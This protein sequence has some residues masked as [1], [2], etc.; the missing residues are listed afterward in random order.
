M[1]PI[2]VYILAVFME[3]LIKNKKLSIAF[4]SIISSYWQLFGYGIGF[5]DELLTGRA[6]KSAQEKLYK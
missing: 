1:L 5:I 4:L 2:A 6:A 3:S